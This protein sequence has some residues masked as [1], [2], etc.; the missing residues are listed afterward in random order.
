MMVK[1]DYFKQ[2]TDL[3]Y[4]WNVPTPNNLKWRILN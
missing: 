2:Y 4:Y 1:H 3:S